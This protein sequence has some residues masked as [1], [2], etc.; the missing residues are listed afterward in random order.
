MS[1]VNY[2]DRM[3]LPSKMT[4][5]YDTKNEVINEY[6]ISSHGSGDSIFLPED[7]ISDRITVKNYEAYFKTYNQENDTIHKV[8]PIGANEF[9]FCGMKNYSIYTK[10]GDEEKVQSFE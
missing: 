6:S 3:E 4:H 7:D 9:I 5:A 1:D 2:E 8:I 10:V